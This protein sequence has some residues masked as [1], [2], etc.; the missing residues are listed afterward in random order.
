[1][2][3]S[4]FTITECMNGENVLN[5]LNRWIGKGGIALH[6]LKP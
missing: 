3:A 6:A 4:C 2:K 1:M 5:A